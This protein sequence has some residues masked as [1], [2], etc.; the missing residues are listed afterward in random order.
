LPHPD[1]DL[2]SKWT[3]LRA[4]VQPG[5]KVAGKVLFKRAYGYHLDIG[6]TFKGLLEII[7]HDED[8]HP[9]SPGDTVD[10]VVTGFLAPVRQVKAST[11]AQDMADRSDCRSDKR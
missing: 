8:G 9:L 7:D 6:L 4:T 3:Q 2:D 1:E 10:A 11:R 5:H